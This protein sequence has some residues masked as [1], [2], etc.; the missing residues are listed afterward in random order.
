MRVAP[1][2]CP[3]GDSPFR[4]KGIAYRGL[5]HFAE[6]RI[7][8]G[9]RALAG[10]VADPR[11]VTFFEQP[12]LA[13]SRYD[14]LPMLPLNAAIADLLGRPLQQVSREAAVGQA[15]YD[16]RNVYRP[17][18]EAHT[19]ADLATRLP[20]FGTQYY[21]FGGYDG[22]DD[23]P[24]HVVIRRTGLPR[25]IVPWYAPMQAAYMEEIVRQLGASRAE[26]TPR[27]EEAAGVDR[28]VEVCELDTDVSF[29]P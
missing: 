19:L 16:A 24:G 5:L 11:L 3:P 13:A 23:G 27:H 18:V 1:L 20:R 17:M 12:F 25:Y 15:R 4:I 26:A 7:R 9:R 10:A 6:M 22:R 29:S 21:D 28:G 2:P 8:G 14:I